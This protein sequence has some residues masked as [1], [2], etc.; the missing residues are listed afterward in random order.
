M[1]EATLFIHEHAEELRN[2]YRKSEELGKLSDR[3]V[4]LLK[5]SGGFRLLLSKDVGG[6]EAHPRDFFEWVIA[7]GSYHPSAGWVAGVCGVH[8]FEFAIAPVKLREE[9][10]GA[11]PD[12]IVASP[13]APFGRAKAVDGGYLLSGRWPYSTGTDHSDWVILGGMVTDETA[14]APAGGVPEIR[15]FVLPKGTD[16]EI[17]DGTWNVLGLGG[18]GSKDVQM[19][20]TFVPAYRTLLEVDV[21]EGVCA[22]REQ[23]GNPLYQMRFLTMFPAAINA[24][25]FGI[26]TGLLREIHAYLDTRVNAV[27]Q[28]AKTDP[29]ILVELARASADVEASVRHFLGEI[30]DLFECVQAGNALTV[31]QR[32]TFRRN[33]V[34]GVERSVTAVNNLYRLA[35]SQAVHKNL[36]LEGFFRDLQ[37]AQSH[38]GNSANPVLQGWALHSFGQEIPRSVF[39]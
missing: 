38:L 18:T 17:V 1:H 29:F 24:G 16:Y 23:P 7:V 14:G 15:H 12:V 31:D 34:A 36:L 39:F 8:P 26:V 20:D 35:G 13:Y 33:H 21:A 37:V 4:E 32:I 5:W 30:D 10:Y 28:A 27:G 2:E 3:T 9:I 22:A 11:D 6:Y 25:T 19:S